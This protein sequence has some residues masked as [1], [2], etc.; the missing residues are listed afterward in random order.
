M[1]WDLNCIGQPAQ[2]MG[3]GI[4]MTGRGI[5]QSWRILENEVKL[6][7]KLAN[8]KDILNSDHNPAGNLFELTVGLEIVH[9]GLFSRD[10]H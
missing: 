4:V 8:I 5:Q 6:N 2:E 1:S 9:A 3:N 7:L 10:I